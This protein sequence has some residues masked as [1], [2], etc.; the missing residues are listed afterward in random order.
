[1]VASRSKA[2]GAI[3]KTMKAAVT[4]NAKS[5]EEKNHTPIK[6]T[7]ESFKRRGATINVDSNVKGPREDGDGVA[8]GKP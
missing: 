3:G 2:G 1:M 8:Q 5:I 6:S 4:P 7:R